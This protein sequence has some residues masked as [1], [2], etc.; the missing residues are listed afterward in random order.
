MEYSLLGLSGLKVSR[1]CF[2]ALTIG[3]TQRNLSVSEG[4]RIISHAF[5]L[6]IN[7][8]DTAKSYGTYP[9]VAHAIKNFPG[10]EIIIA[11]KSH[12]FS[13]NDMRDDVEDCLRQLNRD[14]IDIFLLH[15]QES[16]LT[17]KG[18]RPA[19]EYLLSAKEK[20]LVRAVGISS[21]AVEAVEAAAEMKEIDIIHPMINK[22]GIG[23]IDGNADDMLGAIHKAA[24]A[25]K[26]IYSMKPLGG[27]LLIPEAR[28]A[29]KW[30]LENSDIHSVAIGMQSEAEVEANVA[31]CENR[32]P[33]ETVVDFL[34]VHPRH[35]LISDW[36]EGCGKCAQR[37][38]LKAISIVDN[39]AQVDESKCVLCGYC[40][41]VC[42]EFC[43][44]II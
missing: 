6:G 21:H 39:K 14:V 16:R 26:G 9:H 19:L 13:W 15:E 35:L 8:I 44:K 22:M 27:G 4:S 10:R 28:S 29:F 17:L 41:G 7:F 3:P 34:A 5:D 11:S 23:I 37:C 33:E 1:I 2:G 43:I 24:I 36:C 12:S 20:G 42:R 31:W 30:V 38:G 32:D 18:H 40:A 25:G